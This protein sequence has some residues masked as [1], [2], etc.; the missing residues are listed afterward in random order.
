MLHQHF[1]FQFLNSSFLSL[2]DKIIDPAGQSVR[3]RT[4][5]REK[6]QNESYNKNYVLKKIL[7]TI[8]SNFLQQTNEESHIT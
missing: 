2:E 3:T 8:T 7:Q 6:K 5:S 4:A 1:H